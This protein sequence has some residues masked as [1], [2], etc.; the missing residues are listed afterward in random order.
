MRGPKIKTLIINEVATGRKTINRTMNFCP[1]CQPTYRPIGGAQLNVIV[2]KGERF[3]GG[4]AKL[5]H[6]LVPIYIVHQMMCPDDSAD[7]LIVWF[8]VPNC[9]TADEEKEEP[10]GALIGALTVTVTTTEGEDSET[11]PEVDPD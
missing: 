2:I 5:E 10:D 6:E 1:R 7:R 9:R 4:T 3:A 11:D 8:V